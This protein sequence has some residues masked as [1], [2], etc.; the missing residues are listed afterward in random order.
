MTWAENVTTIHM[1]ED[2]EQLS[3]FQKNVQENCFTSYLN[4]FLFD[5]FMINNYFHQMFK[6][7][8]H[9]ISIL[10]N[11]ILKIWYKNEM[12]FKINMIFHSN[13]AF[14]TAVLNIFCNIAASIA[15]INVNSKINVINIIKFKQ[16]NIEVKIEFSLIVNYIK[17]KIFLIN[18][19]FLILYLTQI[20]LLKKEINIRFTNE[21]CEDMHDKCLSRRRKVND[22]FHNDWKYKNWVSIFFWSSSSWMQ[23]L[24]RFICRYHQLIESTSWLF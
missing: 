2:D 9:I 7:Q 11:I 12:L 1:S 16:N 22:Y 23:S 24:K 18:I 15:F 8:Y 3:S 20:A 6:K 21:E 10:N 17:T 19:F 4:Y 13:I 14:I 5:K